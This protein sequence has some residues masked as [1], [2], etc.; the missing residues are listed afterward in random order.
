MRTVF[1]WFDIVLMHIRHYIMKQ[2]F[3]RTPVLIRITFL[4]PI[5]IISYL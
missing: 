1:L 5:S 2:A 4:L 3:I